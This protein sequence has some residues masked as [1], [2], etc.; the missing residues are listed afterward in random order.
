[1]EKKGNM[2][3]AHIDQVR[4][5]LVLPGVFPSQTHIRLPPGHEILVPEAS[6]TPKAM[7]PASAAPP[8]AGSLWPPPLHAGRAVH[9]LDFGSGAVWSFR[10][11]G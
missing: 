7:R 5:V 2:D 11:P 3:E 4:P 8:V 10:I 1:M 6:G 9:C